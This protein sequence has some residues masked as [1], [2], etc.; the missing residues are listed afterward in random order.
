MALRSLSTCLLCFTSAL[1]LAPLPASSGDALEPLATTAPSLPAGSIALF[2]DRTG[3]TA[4]P[5]TGNTDEE[6]S[7]WTDVTMAG[8][9]KW[10]IF[11]PKD[12]LGYKTNNVGWYGKGTPGLAPAPIPGLWPVKEGAAGA[13]TGLGDAFD[14]S[15]MIAINF[16]VAGG[17]IGPTDAVQA[18]FAQRTNVP[19]TSVSVTSKAM[20]AGA[21]QQEAAAVQL[22]ALGRDD[23][24]QLS[25]QA[26]A[27]LSRFPPTMGAMNQPSQTGV[28]LQPTTAA[29]PE[30]L[31]AYGAMARA[32][33]MPHLL[34]SEQ[35]N[36]TTQ[37][38]SMQQQQPPPLPPPP[39]QQ[40]QQGGAGGAIVKVAVPCNENASNEALLAGVASAS[41]HALLSAV[42]GS[43]NCDMVAS[44]LAPLSSSLAA[45]AELLNA[46]GG[47]CTVLAS[48][49]P[50]K[51]KT[52]AEAFMSYRVTNAASAVATATAA[53]VAGTAAS[54]EH[55]AQTM[56]AASRAPAGLDAGKVI[57]QNQLDEKAPLGTTS[58]SDY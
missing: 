6:L 13:A 41:Q 24:R 29:L 20:V 34:T 51:F 19:S 58:D 17:D 47:R 22:G 52:R 50:E 5:I 42:P 28:M 27:Q 55:Y 37:L 32:R 11:T 4:L 3:R 1:A 56:A 36:A 46:G 7:D 10:G 35:S 57:V 21:Q 44:K 26:L 25:Q 16:H 33:G 48:S 8:M 53:D 15:S 14:A 45:A 12:P 30:S 43:R 49:A 23:E 2:S 39:P 31:E 54:S 18:A 9:K 38:I 40:Q